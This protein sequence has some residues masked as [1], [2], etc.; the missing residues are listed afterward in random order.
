MDDLEN[1][2]D[3]SKALA[4]IDPPKGNRV[5]AVSTSGGI[6]VLA[7]DSI[8]HSGL[9]LPRL[10][11]QF[12]RA[13]RDSGIPPLAVLSNP[14]D[15]VSIRAE[16]FERVVEIASEYDVADIILLGFGDPVEGGADMVKKLA[17]RVKTPLVVTYLGGGDEP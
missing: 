2:Y 8:E 7:A 9:N 14:L 11:D 6:G 12:V 15:L 3:A 10:S 17:S 5:F 1:L 4:L 16:Y 13:L